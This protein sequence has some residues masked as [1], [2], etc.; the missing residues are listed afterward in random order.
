MRWL[1]LVAHWKNKDLTRMRDQ[2]I[3]TKKGENEE[4]GQNDISMLIELRGCGTRPFYVKWRHVVAHLV[5]YL[6]A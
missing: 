4:E 6:Q 5:K 1:L 2:K 3:L